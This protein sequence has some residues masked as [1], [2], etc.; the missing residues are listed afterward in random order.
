MSS[1]RESTSEQQYVTIARVVKTQG[2]IGEVAAMLATDFPERFATRRKLFALYDTAAKPSS[3]GVQPGQRRELQLEE[4][5]F[6][7]GMVVLKFAGVDSINDAEA[8][9]GCEIQIPQSERA[10]LEADEFYVSDLVGCTVFD[11]G[12]EIGRIKDVQF[13]SGEAP[14]LV[15]EG[16]KEQLIPFA[17]AYIEKIALEQ[18]RVEMKLPEG[19]LELDAPLNQEEKQR[20]QNRF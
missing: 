7:K 18:K 13:G 19:L 16:A 9:I 17:A 10:A 14:L 2:R 12:R 8:F 1:S 5:W 4:H 6:H 20:Q 15:V 11:A 3:A